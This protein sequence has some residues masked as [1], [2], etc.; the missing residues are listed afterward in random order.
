VV[1]SALTLVSL[2]ATSARAE[3]ILVTTT[4]DGGAG[5]LR[6]AF[7]IANGNGQADEIVLQ[8]GATYDLTLCGGAG[9]EDANADGDLDH[10]APEALS[11][12][13]NDATIRNTCPDERV[14][15]LVVSGPFS[16]IATTV[17]GGDAPGDGGAI[18]SVGG[19]QEVKVTGASFVA[20]ESTG[21]GGAIESTSSPISVVDSTFTQNKAGT[22]GSGDGGALE[23]TDGGITVLRSTIAGNT[24]GG[25]G[26]GIRTCCDTPITVTDSAIT[27][28]QAL[29][30]TGGGIHTTD[31]QIDI[32]RSTISGN[33]A[34]NDGGAVRTSGDPLFPITVSDSTISGN[35]SGA[36]G[37]GFRSSTSPIM[38]ENTTVSG[39]SAASDG[40][41][42]RTTLAP[43]TANNVTFQGNSATAEGQT[44]DADAAVQLSNTILSGASPTCTGVG[45]FT[46]GGYN[47]ATDTTCALPGTGDQNADPMLAPL[48]DNGGPTQTHALQ[49][50]SP[51]VNAGNP[52]PAGSG[53]SACAG[54]DQRGLPRTGA[55]DIG[56]YELTFCQQVPVNRIG[57]PGP[58]VLTGT[59][60][61]DGFLAFGGDDRV[62][63]LGGSDGVC[64]GPGKD[65][66]SGGGGK[67]RLRGEGGRDL[68]KGGGGKDRLNGGPG[69]DTCVGQGGKDKASACE[70]EKGIP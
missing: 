8:A 51:A 33:T 22:D 34:A 70:T 41:A 52:A 43:V 39:N 11:I 44:F 19:S 62:R 60:G 28:N 26:G 30:S 65:R 68:L 59:A 27:G 15:H 14:I 48:A 58:D 32:V 61:P 21:D 23:T 35:T 54:T 36:D 63:A 12:T 50:G 40:G 18:E 47:V 1:A 5:S 4:A 56:A 29:G 13:G 55:C 66:A 10:I 64:A 46:S 7:D 57:T 9:Q 67:D 3:V 38:L 25:S 2:G 31:S 6:T 42:I 53:G 17:T 45:P 24:A 37:G 20:N 16:L 49:E 69:R